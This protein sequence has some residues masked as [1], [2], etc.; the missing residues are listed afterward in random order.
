MKRAIAAVVGSALA[1]TIVLGPRTAARQDEHRA[2]LIV[3]EPGETHEMCLFFDEEEITGAELL[4]RADLDAVVDS[5][6]RGSA[7]CRIDGTGCERGDCF[8]NYPSFWGY[9]T[10]DGDDWTFAD[11]GSAE[12]VVEDGSVDGWSYGRDGKP[13]PPDRTFDDVCGAAASPTEL[14]GGEP[15][16]TPSGSLSDYAAF[17]AIAGALLAIAAFLVVRRRRTGP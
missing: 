12:R 7:V 11:V 2:A 4:R 14:R 15:L 6:G 10:R 8:C 17:L 16:R 9:W 1:L 5:G 13:A 3:R